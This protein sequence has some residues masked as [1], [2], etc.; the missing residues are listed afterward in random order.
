MWQTTQQYQWLE[1]W[2]KSWGVPFN[3]T[4]QKS[5]VFRN[6]KWKKSLNLKL[7][8]IRISGMCLCLRA[9]QWPHFLPGVLI[10]LEEI[11][12]SDHPCVYRLC[13]WPSIYSWNQ[14]MFIEFKVLFWNSL[15]SI[16]FS[17]LF[18]G[19]TFNLKV[20]PGK[21]LNPRSFKKL[22]SKVFQ[23]RPSERPSDFNT[24]VN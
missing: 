9:A 24:L 14:S 13:V 3:K 23:E 20:C 6:W 21:I 19:K 11:T 2:P 22:D 16:S 18:P 12:I 1:L 4:S 17:R 15:N 8:T 10:K 5:K 7:K